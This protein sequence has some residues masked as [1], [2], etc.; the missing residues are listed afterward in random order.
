VPA[1]MVDA[2]FYI[3]QA[4]RIFGRQHPDE[5]GAEPC[6][7]GI[8]QTALFVAPAA[9]LVFQAMPEGLTV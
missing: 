7:Q 6:A 2:G 1:V 3:T 5:E 8:A 4:Q 9:V